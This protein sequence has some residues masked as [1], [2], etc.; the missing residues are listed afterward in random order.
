MGIPEHQSGRSAAM[1]RALGL[2]CDI[3]REDRSDARA[4][5]QSTYPPALTGMRGSGYA[6]AY[7][8]GHAL[9]NGNLAD[10]LPRLNPWTGSM[11]SSS[12]VAA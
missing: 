3:P 11:T 8:A 10:A 9:R 2:A 1:D 5:H 6:R 4:E 12:S 7:C